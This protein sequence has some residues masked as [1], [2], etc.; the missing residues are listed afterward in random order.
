MFPIIAGLPTSNHWSKMEGFC[1][2][3]DLQLFRNSTL[4]AAPEMNKA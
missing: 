3:M 4:I 1:F 2:Q